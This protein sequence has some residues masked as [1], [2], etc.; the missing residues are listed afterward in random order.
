MFVVGRCAH[1]VARLGTRPAAAL[2]RRRSHQFSR[3]RDV[4]LFVPRPRAR[5]DV[6]LSATAVSRRRQPQCGHRAGRE[7]GTHRV[8]QTELRRFHLCG[9]AIGLTRKPSRQHV[10]SSILDNHS[11]ARCG[12]RARSNTRR[13]DLFH[14]HRDTRRFRPIH[15]DSNWW[16]SDGVVQQPH[17]ADLGFTSAGRRTL[18]LPVFA[19]LR[20]QQADSRRSHLGKSCKCGAS[21][22]CD[23]ALVWHPGCRAAPGTRSLVFR[24]PQ[25]RCCTAPGCSRRGDLC[26]HVLLGNI[27]VRGVVTSRVRPTP[28]ALVDRTGRCGVR[29]RTPRAQR[30]CST[31]LSR[32]RCNVGRMF[33]R[34]RGAR[35]YGCRALE[36]HFARSASRKPARHTG[37]SAALPEGSRVRAELRQPGR[38]HLC[39]TLHA[40]RLLLERP[41]E[42]I[43]LRPHDPGQ[44]RR[45]SY[46]RKPRR[47]RDTMR[48]L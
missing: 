12:R 45:Q 48:R 10:G 16:R 38:G 20:F 6:L 40:D 22:C 15:R 18:H 31:G 36:Q 28:G 34:N 21:R 44:R 4:Q 3:A 8:L 41:P 37:T 42:R 24:R 14:I 1:D 17:P 32:C 39:R 9:V 30:S 27:P 5:N 11:V 19:T 25:Q 23:S 47:R 7:P 2:H 46:H 26:S 13:C 43:A 29:R 33:A 35:V